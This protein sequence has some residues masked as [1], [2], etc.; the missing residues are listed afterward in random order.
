MSHTHSGKHSLSDGKKN[1]GPFS[2][3][4]KS[5]LCEVSRTDC[6]KCVILHVRSTKT[7][8]DQRG[9]LSVAIKRV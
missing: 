4:L 1:G 6:P 8:K 9:S 2:K 7:I 3:P 5:L